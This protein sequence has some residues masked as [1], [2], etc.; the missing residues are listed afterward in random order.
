MFLPVVRTLI[1]SLLFLLAVP[2]AHGRVVVVATGTDQVQ[3]IDIRTNVPA[4]VRVPGQ[5][6]R[7]AAGGI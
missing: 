6:Y 7:C 1:A 4:G 2:A 3:L 5:P